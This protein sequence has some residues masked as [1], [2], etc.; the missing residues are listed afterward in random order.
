ML[1]GHRVYAVLSSDDYAALAGPLGGRTC[2]IDRRST[3]D[4]KLKR[5]LARQPLPE[6]LLITNRCGMVG[7]A[8]G[9]WRSALG[10]RGR[11]RARRSNVGSWRFASLSMSED[12]FRFITMAYGGAPEVYRQALMLLV[13]LVA[14]APEP[15]RLVVATDR[16]ECYVWFGTRVDI[17]YLDAARL[18]AWRGPDPFSMRQKLE[19]AR[20]MGAAATGPV[21]L[22]DA[23]VLAVQPLG[24]FVAQLRTGA[25]FMHRREFGLARSSRPGNRRL[26]R[27]LQRHAS[28]IPAA[29]SMWNSGVLAF[30]AADAPLI[31]AALTLYDRFAADGLRHF[32]TEQ[33]V[34]A[35]TLEP[36]GRLRP[37]ADWF[38]HYWGNK[39]GYDGEIACR[40]ADAFIE[41]MS[42]KDAAAAYL[43]QP[44]TLAPEV[45][46]TRPQKIRRWFGR[47]AR[48]QASLRATRAARR[49]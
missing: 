43:A 33:L 11:A 31:D 21:V 26:W 38:I 35:L 30:A 12:P 10:R 5:V 2:V 29:A 45:R 49:R 3:F 7:A 24:P 32:A 16:P 41:G 1:S 27:W 47:A 8:I 42:V 37:A 22:L 25:L 20:A 34:E 17:E 46:S 13:S 44:L 23:D 9:A 28:P 6:L 48:D 36:T 18:D 14:H 15:L 39:P 4:V 19:L 40:L